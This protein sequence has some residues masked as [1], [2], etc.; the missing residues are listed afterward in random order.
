MRSLAATLVLATLTVASPGI[1]QDVDELTKTCI[2]NNRLA[3]EAELDGNFE[4]AVVNAEACNTRT[5]AEVLRKDC[6]EI[7]ERARAKLPPPAPAPPPPEQPGTTPPPEPPP[8][9]PAPMPKAPAPARSRV[10]SY[11]LAGVAAVGAG[12]FAFFALSGKSKED[13]LACSPGC[14][15][16][17]LDPI[18]RDYLIADISL[19]VSVVALAGSLYFWPWGESKEANK[20]QMSVAPDRLRVRYSF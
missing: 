11:V 2:E 18:T 12:S 19:G 15:D 14:P 16:D 1:A 7:A 8:T 13:D 5:C 9:K 10:P 20:L 17:R 6:A 3:Q 4:Q